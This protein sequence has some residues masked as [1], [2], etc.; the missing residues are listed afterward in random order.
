MISHTFHVDPLP[1]IQGYSPVPPGPDLS[2][3]VV[4]L[5]TGF[6]RDFSE[7]SHVS[8]GIIALTLSCHKRIRLC[9]IRPMVHFF[10]SSSL[11]FSFGILEPL[12]DIYI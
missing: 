12:S 8:S 5:S 10:L 4:E 2:S 3:L 7:G 6:S 11:I 9:L 1:P